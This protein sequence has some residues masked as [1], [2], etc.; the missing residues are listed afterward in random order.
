[1]VRSHGLGRLMNAR[2]IPPTLGA[3]I[4]VAFAAT[5]IGLAPA[6]GADTEPEPFQDLFG[7]TGINSWT[8]SADSFLV[9]SDPTLAASLDTSVE[10]FFLDIPGSDPFSFWA[11]LLDP[12]AFSY[13]PAGFGYVT[14]G[15]LPLNASADFAIGLDYTLFA[16][17]LGATVDPGIWELATI[18]D[19]LFGAG[20]F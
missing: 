9:S 1:M 18:Y 11:F 16:S 12:S 3:A 6:A 2:R 19:S 8:A 7:D 13:D 4:G 20:A 15:G 5:L 17:G 10:N 14:D